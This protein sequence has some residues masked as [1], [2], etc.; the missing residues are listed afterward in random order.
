MRNDTII[1]VADLTITL[2]GETRTFAS[3]IIGG[4]EYRGEVGNPVGTD[5]P[6]QWIDWSLLQGLYTLTGADFIEV[7]GAIASEMC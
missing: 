2:T 3:V 5:A 6:D 4:R 1:H 7:C